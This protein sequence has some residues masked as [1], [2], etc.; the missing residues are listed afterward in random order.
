MLGVSCVIF[1][2]D[3][4]LKRL[5]LKRRSMIFPVN[6]SYDEI[7]FE[8]YMI[9]RDDRIQNWD[10]LYIPLIIKCDL[11]LDC[12]YFQAKYDQISNRIRNETMLSHRKL[13]TCT[14]KAI[15]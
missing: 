15:Y 2:D 7:L 3:C 13:Q 4:E 9:Q 14:K 1:I 11:Y 5:C 10:I 12:M 6:K 8:N